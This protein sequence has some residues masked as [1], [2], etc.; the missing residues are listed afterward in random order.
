MPN[1]RWRAESS[2]DAASPSTGDE[3]SGASPKHVRSPVWGSVSRS[4]GKSVGLGRGPRAAGCGSVSPPLEHSCARFLAASD[5]LWHVASV[6]ELVVEL[7]GT[8]QPTRLILPDGVA[9]FIA[10]TLLN[11]SAVFEYALVRVN[12]GQERIRSRFNLIEPIGSV[13]LGRHGHPSRVDI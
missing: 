1:P 2:S 12:E 4:R 3:V 13:H 6:I 11:G 9:T 8:Q 10:S 5:A 7:A